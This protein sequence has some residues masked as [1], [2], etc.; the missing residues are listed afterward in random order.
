MTDQRS[1]PSARR[2]A[3]SLVRCATVYDATPKMPIDARSS[4]RTLKNALSAATM[5]SFAMSRSMS[6]CIVLIPTSSFGLMR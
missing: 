5:R 6:S 1:A 2:I 4:P 3:S